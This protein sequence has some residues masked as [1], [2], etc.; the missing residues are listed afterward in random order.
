MFEQHRA[1]K[2]RKY[3]LKKKNYIPS[4]APLLESYR[5][6]LIVRLANKC[7]DANGSC[8]FILLLKIDII[9]FVK[10]KK[11]FVYKHMQL[12]AHELGLYPT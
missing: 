8:I 7:G 3:I 10:M 4:S 5:A 9:I 11:F 12:L 2:K 1:G 6:M